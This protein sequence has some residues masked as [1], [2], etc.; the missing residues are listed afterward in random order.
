VTG[1]DEHADEDRGVEAR[2]ALFGGNRVGAGEV[3]GEEISHQQSLE[4]LVAGVVLEE[5][6]DGEVAA[7][8]GTQVAVVERA[9]QALFAD[10]LVEHE[11]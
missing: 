10:R 4:G 1:E 5:G 9:E 3:L 11:V 7:A 6:E 2:V 8:Q